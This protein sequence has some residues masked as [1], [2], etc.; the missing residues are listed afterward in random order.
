MNELPSNLSPTTRWTIRARVTNKSS[1]RTWSNSR[2]DGKL[3]SMEIVDESVSTIVV[4]FNLIHLFAYLC[5]KLSVEPFFDL[6]LYVSVS[7][8]LCYVF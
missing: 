4:L 2:G 5:W 6:S 3:F 7:A 1:I 8:H